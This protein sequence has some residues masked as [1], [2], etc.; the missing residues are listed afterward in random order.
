MTHVQGQKV[1]GQCHAVNITNRKVSI[2]YR[3]SRLAGFYILLLFSFFFF[4]KIRITLAGL[5]MGDPAEYI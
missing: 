1:I 3:K 2:I 5:R 4:L